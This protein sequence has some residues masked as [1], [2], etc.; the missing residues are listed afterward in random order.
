[1]GLGAILD[2]AE[3]R[4]KHVRVFA[5]EG[6]GL[7]EWFATRNVDVERKRLP[8]GVDE[9]F[10]VGDGEFEAAITVAELEAFLDPE[11]RRP[12]DLDDLSPAYRSVFELFDDTV[13]ASLDRRQLL[14]TVR[15]L[16]ERAWRTGRGRVHAGFQ[17]PEA[18]HAQA[19]LYRR[20][21]AESDLEVHVHLDG[22]VD[23]GDRSPASV[24]YHDGPRPDVG[25][26][27]FFAFD[28][29]PD[30]EAACSLVAEQCDDD[31]YAGVWS[32]DPGVVTP[33]FDAVT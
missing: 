10:V 4:R 27:W 25:R 22:S 29:G 32:Y 15:E 5:R 16:E 30:S 17:R 21:A 24:A 3:R 14:A 18:H 8:P 9:P 26:F 1:M 11:I 31:A 33:V 19:E 2:A 7:G 12:W 6:A 28:G 23:E 20:L 13:F